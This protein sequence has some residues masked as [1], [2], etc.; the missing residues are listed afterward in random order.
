MCLTP[1]TSWFKNVALS[2]LWKRDRRTEAICTRHDNACQNACVELNAQEDVEY[3]IVCVFLL[4]D[5]LT[6]SY[7]FRKTTR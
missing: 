1:V 7:H 5:F 3:A 2:A 4:C 6:A